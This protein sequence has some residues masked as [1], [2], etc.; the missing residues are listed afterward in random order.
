MSARTKQLESPLS[1]VDAVETLTQIADLEFDKEVGIAKKHDLILQDRK[2]TYRTI[3]W[4]HQEDVDST[5]K[6]VRETFRVI[7]TYLKHFYEREYGQI[8]DEKTIEG[9]KTIM[10]LVGEAAK[11]LDRYTT[12]FHTKKIKSISELKEYKNLQK[13]Y[14]SKISRK[15]DEGI[16]S[17]W[18]LALAETAKTKRRKIKLTGEKKFDTKKVFVDLESVKRDLDYELFFLRKEDGT[19][20]FNPRLIR[21]IKLVCD[22]GSYFDTKK[23]SDPLIDVKLWYDY[24]MHESAQNLLQSMGYLLD[25][26]TS[27]A[28]HAQRQEL[29][30]WINKA[31]FALYLAANPENSA[32]SCPVKCCFEYLQDFQRFLRKALLCRQYQKMIAY[33]PKKS[34]KFNNCL[35][36]TVH[37]LCRGLYSQLFSYQNILPILEDLLQEAEEEVSEEQIEE[38]EG[39]LWGRLAQEHASMIRLMRRHPNGPLVKVL[40]YL[41]SGGHPTYDTYMESN[42]PNQWYAFYLTDRRMLNLHLPSPT[43]QEFIQK[44][45]INEEFK[46]F[47]RAALKDHIVNKVLLFNLQDRTSWKEYARAKQLEELTDNSEFQGHINVVTLSKDTA[48]YHQ[49]A[50]Y[51]EETDSMRFIEEFMNNLSD[52]KAGNFFPDEIAQKLFPKFTD[53]LFHAIHRIFFSHRNVMTREER[54]D[55]IEIAYLFIELKILELIKPDVFAFTCKDGIDNGSTSSAELY[56]FVSL[57]N[58][59]A[60]RDQD[61]DVIT[62][63]LYGPSLLIRERLLQSDRFHR[64]LSC[65]KC[66]EELREELGFEN[67]DLVI[68]EGFG[69]LFQGAVF[70]MTRS[71][72]HG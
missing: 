5:V 27:D 2:V 54:L 59:D 49:L 65:F 62:T 26:Y 1:I 61:F 56:G 19:W 25:R 47:L 8:T 51:H 39:K 28:M 24:F 44:A 34:N 17:K 4:V 3:H 48:F 42:L 60:P 52:S 22:F 72:P 14:H 38:G 10:V 7:L 43:H 67:F 13:F 23:R 12:L 58:E 32:R 33:P 30:M 31:I 69:R 36:D 71:G 29:V 35:L 9:I 55:F 40:D 68:K 66:I 53:E 57:L 45:T 70:T 20:F 63:I 11:K 16:L 41:E 21:N 46:G 50:P 6:L 64:M 18:I 37:G 15:V